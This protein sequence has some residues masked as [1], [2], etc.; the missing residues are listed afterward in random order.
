M[1]MN[2]EK[3]KWYSPALRERATA[4]A[5]EIGATRASKVLGL[6]RTIIAKW[7]GRKRDGKHMSAS[8]TPEQR[9]LMKTK[10]ELHKVQR[11]NEDLK[12]ANLVLRELA[13]FFSKDHPST[14]LEW[15]LK[16]MKSGKKS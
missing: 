10:R 14:D 3:G 4:L 8:D 6:P 1:A 15:S 2:K 11:E 9:E 5:G 13:S 7:L 16:S 12:K